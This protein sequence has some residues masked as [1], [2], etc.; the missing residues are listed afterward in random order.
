M[1]TCQFAHYQT[2]DYHTKEALFMVWGRTFISYRGPVPATPM[3]QA[4]DVHVPPDDVQ[5]IYM[6]QM[7]L[8]NKYHHDPVEY[9][10]ETSNII[11]ADIG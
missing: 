6:L 9:W 2:V 10:K 5:L 4:G 1:L 7:L 8:G 3:H 11:M